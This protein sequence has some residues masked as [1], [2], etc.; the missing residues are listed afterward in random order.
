[1][2]IIVIVAIP[3]LSS[4]TFVILCQFLS[5]SHPWNSSLLKVCYPIKLLY[6][7]FL[8][9]FSLFWTFWPAYFLPIPH[10]F[11]SATI[12]TATSNYLSRYVTTSYFC[13]IYSF[14]AQNS[15]L[16][17]LFT[18]ASPYPHTWIVYLENYWPLKE[19]CLS[20]IAKSIAVTC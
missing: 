15:L 4:L 11:Q 13:P 12:S 7:P 18:T 19:S 17:C 5:L 20:F 8:F 16:F 14:K 2:I 3:L 10:F 6:N 9:L 1:M